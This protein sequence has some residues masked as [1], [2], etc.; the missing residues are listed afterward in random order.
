MNKEE[1]TKVIKVMLK[2]DGGCRWCA[3]SLIDDFSE[4]FKTH[5]LLAQKL[6]KDMYGEDNVV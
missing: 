6:Y 4:T 3:R 1:A 2:A 5:K